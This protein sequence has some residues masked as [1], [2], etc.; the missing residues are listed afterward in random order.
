MKTLLTVICLSAISSAAFADGIVIKNTKN[1]VQQEIEFKLD[2]NAC[3]LKLSEGWGGMDT[4]DRCE[5]KIK[6]PS[7]G[8]L[9]S[10]AV[11]GNDNKIAG[12]YSRGG[13]S[14]QGADRFNNRQA[15]VNNLTLAIAAGK[16][17][18][19]AVYVGPQL[20]PA[21]KASADHDVGDEKAAATSAQ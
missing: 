6:L 18:V 1:I 2:A 10:A 7:G 19:K 20:S 8:K 3:E 15:F 13:V 9:I 5:F 16:F 12:E 11:V 17:T 4:G 21:S 14:F